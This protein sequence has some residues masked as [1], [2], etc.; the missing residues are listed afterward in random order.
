MKHWYSQV[1]FLI[2]AGTL[3]FAAFG[4]CNLTETRCTYP[5]IEYY[6]NGVD[7]RK[8]KKECKEVCIEYEVKKPHQEHVPQTEES[9]A[10]KGSQ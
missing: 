4:F 5:C 2:V 6:S 7:C 10:K 3:S 9:A 1:L 8:T